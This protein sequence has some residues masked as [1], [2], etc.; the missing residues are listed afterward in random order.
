M[1]SSVANTRALV[2]GFTHIAADAVP[3]PQEG[4]VSQTTTESTAPATTESKGFCASVGAF[5]NNLIDT[6]CKTVARFFNT[7][8]NCFAGQA[9]TPVNVIDQSS[10]APS[11]VTP[12]EPC[13]F[14]QP[15]EDQSSTMPSSVTPPEQTQV[16]TPASS[17]EP[18]RSLAAP[19]PATSLAPTQVITRS[20]AAP[21]PATPLAS[22]RVITHSSATPLFSVTSLAQTR[23]ITPA[24]SQ[25]LQRS[26]ATPLFPVTSLAQTRLITPVSSQKPR[27]S[28]AVLFPV[29]PLAQSRG[30]TP[31]SSQKTQ[32]SPTTPLSVTP[33]SQPRVITPASNQEPQHSPVGSLLFTSLASRQKPQRS[34]SAP[35][36]TLS[37]RER[38][39]NILRSPGESRSPLNVCIDQTPGSPRTPRVLKRDKMGS[40]S[41]TTLQRIRNIARFSKTSESPSALKRDNVGSPGASRSP[42]TSR[43]LKWSDTDS[44]GASRFLTPLEIP[45]IQLPLSESSFKPFTIK[46][47]GDLLPPFLL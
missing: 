45:V 36:R 33:L 13:I 4:A 47:S 16:I 43:P 38:I 23:L 7:I 22:T 9:S 46:I 29:T 32:H 3:L 1:I 6:V 39:E 44:P 2:V 12:P 40:P 26:S 17:Q 18:Q 8:K 31:A 42:L 25:K 35:P 34:P 20:S 5:L 30:I 24:S 27:L 41:G 19:L 28:P 37:L 10:T 15:A 14:T 11:S 21:L